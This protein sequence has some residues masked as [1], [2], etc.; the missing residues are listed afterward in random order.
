MRRKLGKDGLRGEA[1]LEPVDGD[2]VC[3]GANLEQES[4]LRALEDEVWAVIQR[5]QR[6]NVSITPDE[7][8]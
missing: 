7:D 6:G 8:M 3:L 2:I 5:L 1:G 4:L